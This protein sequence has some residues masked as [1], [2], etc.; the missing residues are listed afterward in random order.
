MHGGDVA[1]ALRHQAGEFL[2]AGKP[3]KFQRIETL[4]GFLRQGLL[5]LHLRLGLDL[6]LAQLAAQ[7]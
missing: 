7:A 5:G 3:V 4:P 6:D 1:H 2:K